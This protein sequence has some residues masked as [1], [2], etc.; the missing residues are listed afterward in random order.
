MYICPFAAKWIH[1]FRETDGWTGITKI[2]GTFCK[3]TN[4]SNEELYV[5]ITA[6]LKGAKAKL[7][8]P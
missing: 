2:V 6:D 4:A 5:S 1:T 3:F 8:G 7:K